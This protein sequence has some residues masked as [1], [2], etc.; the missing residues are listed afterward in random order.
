VQRKAPVRE[1][2][3]LA[4]PARVIDRAITAE[5]FHASDAVLQAAML[6]QAGIS[7]SSYFAGAPFSGSALDVRANGRWR[8]KRKHP[9]RL[10]FPAEHF[11]QLILLL[12]G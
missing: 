2:V 4:L 7:S 5:G 8:I 11:D 9:A 6:D 10:A 12:T 1:A 3:A